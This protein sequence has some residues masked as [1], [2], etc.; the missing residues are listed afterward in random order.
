MRKE[1]ESMAQ[2]YLF[3]NLRQVEMPWVDG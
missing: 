1:L 3:M 2:K